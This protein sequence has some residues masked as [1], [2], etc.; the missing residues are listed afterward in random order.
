MQFQSNGENIKITKKDVVIN[1]HKNV[2]DITCKTQ[3][4]KSIHP[5]LS[6]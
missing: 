2:K 3:V 5:F 1:S 4:I 6:H